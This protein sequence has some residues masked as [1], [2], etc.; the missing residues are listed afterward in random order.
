MKKEILEIR[1]LITELNEYTAAY[2][3]G[4]PSISDKEWDELYFRLE[5]L[6]K[7]TGILYPNLK[8]N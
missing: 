7:K 3:Q 6:E 1:D 4:N 2:N 8:M 5:E